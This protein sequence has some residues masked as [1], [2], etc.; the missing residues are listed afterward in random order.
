VPLENLA[1]TVFIFNRN[2]LAAFT[3]SNYLNLSNPPSHTKLLLKDDVVLHSGTVNVVLHSDT[4]NVVLHSGTVNDLVR[5][6][7]VIFCFLSTVNIL[8]V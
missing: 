5:L 7:N 6:S 1:P 3:K 4:V 8:H 2:L